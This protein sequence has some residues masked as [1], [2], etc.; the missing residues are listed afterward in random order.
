MDLLI[1]LAKEGNVED[2]KEYLDLD[3]RLVNYENDDGWRV[4]RTAGKAMEM[5]QF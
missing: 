3:P 4:R 2:L 5:L 1:T